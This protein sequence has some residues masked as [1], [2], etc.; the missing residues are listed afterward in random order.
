MMDINMKKIILSIIISAISFNALSQMIFNMPIPQPDYVSNDW[1][2]DG[3]PNSS[4]NDDDNDGIDDD[5]DSTPFGQGGQSST[6]DVVLNYFTSNKITIDSNESFT[7]SWDFENERNLTLYDDINKTNLINDVTGLNFISLNNVTSDKSFYLDYITG[8][9]SLDVFTWMN[10]GTNCSG[11]SPSPSTVD[12]GTQFTQYS[13]CITN[14]T[15][16]EPN[17]KS[18]SYNQSKQS[19]GTKVSFVCSYSYPGNYVRVNINNDYKIT[20]AYYYIN[21]SLVGNI[22]SNGTISYASASNLGTVS[23]GGK[24]YKAGSIKYNAWSD[25]T[26]NS[27]LSIC[28]K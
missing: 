1:D 28:V 5:L 18:I 3:I 21:N 6:P 10:T 16:N 13:T 7:L 19:T 14:Y 24:L 2:N 8:T 27:R 23:H 12:S 17:S 20:N 4:D 9:A 25:S 15:S 22:A 26:R 11:Y